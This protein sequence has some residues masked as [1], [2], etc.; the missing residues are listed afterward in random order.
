[1]SGDEGTELFYGETNDHDLFYE[2]SYHQKQSAVKPWWKTQFFVVEPVLFGT[3]DGVFTSCLINIFGVVMFLRTGWVVGNVGIG[4]ATVIVLFTLLVALLAALSAIGVC[5]RISEMKSGGVYVIVSTVLG[6]KIGGAIGVMYAFGLSAVSALYCTGFAESI[7]ETFDWYNEWAVRGIAIGTLAVLLAINLAGVKWVI[8]LQLL[9]LVIL[10][11]STVD[12]FVGT[13]THTNPEEGFLGYSSEVFNNNTEP[14]FGEGEDFFSVFGVFFPTAT[15]IMAGVNM[16]GDLKHPSKS[17]P[18]GTLSAIFL[19][20]LLYMLYVF[21]LGAT[22]TRNALQTNFMI[23][24]TVSAVGVL[25]LIGV[26][27][28]ST[29]SGSTGLYGAP[30]VLQSIADEKVVPGVK[31]IGRGFGANKTPVYAICVVGIVSLGF[32]LIGSMNLISPVITCNFLF[33]YAAVDYSYFALAMSYD[34]KCFSG[35]TSHS[36]SQSHNRKRKTSDIQEE[37]IND[38]ARQDNTEVKAQ[39]PEMPSNTSE[40]DITNSD[41]NIHCEDEI[42]INQGNKTTVQRRSSESTNYGTMDNDTEP[43]QNIDASNPNIDIL[44]QPKSWYSFACNRWSSLFGAFLSIVIMFLI[45]WIAALANILV[46][47]II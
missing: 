40:N 34:L 15:G 25:W 14:L 37:L 1:M 32:I 11:V 47:I 17:I 20:L 44:S 33:V 6:G 24:E 13:F 8:R 9:L 29:S 39:L 18:V 5:E 16:S 21:L 3:W 31:Y 43:S 36:P 22:C 30:R 46:Y 38:E 7:T 10:F 19:T 28:S 12:F 42:K 45:N 26:Y 4:L 27:M 41:N 2:E 35:K 23:G